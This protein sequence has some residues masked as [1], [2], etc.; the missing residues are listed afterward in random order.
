MGVFMSDQRRLF[1]SSDYAS[2][3]SCFCII[4]FRCSCQS[5]IVISRSN[6]V[7]LSKHYRVFCLPSLASHHGI[8]RY[9]HAPQSYKQAPIGFLPPAFAVCR[10]IW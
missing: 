9:L 3:V 7:V 2:S 5:L 6:T 10:W 8:A 1:R 4:S